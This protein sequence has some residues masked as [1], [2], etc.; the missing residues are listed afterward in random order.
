VRLSRSSRGLQV[1]VGS[2]VAVAAACFVIAGAA[3]AQAPL[4]S[5]PVV[6]GCLGLLVIGVR[7]HLPLRLG[8]QRIELSWSEVGLVLAFGLAPRSGWCC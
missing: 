1:V 2:A 5:P 3:A 8:A 4:P 7:L 6:A